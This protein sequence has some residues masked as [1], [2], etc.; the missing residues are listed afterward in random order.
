[1][2]EEGVNLSCIGGRGWEEVEVDAAV[3]IQEGCVD[4]RDNEGW[5]TIGAWCEE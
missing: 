3:R 4:T 5:K 1:M 2:D